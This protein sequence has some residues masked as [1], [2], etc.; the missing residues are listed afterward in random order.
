[1][2]K[3]ST[4]EEC[5]VKFADQKMGE[6]TDKMSKIAGSVSS[7]ATQ[8]WDKLEQVFEERVERALSR[9]GVPTNKDIQQLTERIEALSS[10]IADL[11]GQNPTK[12]P[13]KK[14][15]RAKKSS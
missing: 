12:A 10:A 2:P 9:L 4:N 6:V 13:A 8:H 11:T 7:K 3:G 5:S 15:T 14:T 1:M